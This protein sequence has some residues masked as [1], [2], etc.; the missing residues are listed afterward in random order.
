MKTFPKRWLIMMVAA[1]ILITIGLKEA[2]AQQYFF[3][4]GKVESLYR[5]QLT[6]KGDKGE[7][8]YFAIGRRTVYIPSRLPGVGERVKVTYFLRRGHNVASQVEIL[9]P[10]SPPKK[11]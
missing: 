1:G 7:T 4:Q 2:S 8:M 10:P 6:V 9:P 11:K 3:F 5:E